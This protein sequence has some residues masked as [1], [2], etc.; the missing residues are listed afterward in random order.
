MSIQDLYYSPQPLVIAGP[1]AV[2]WTN[3]DTHTH[4]TTGDNGEWDSGRLDP[5]QSF[6]NTIL[7][8]RTYYFHCTIHTC[9]MGSLTVNP[10]SCTQ[11]TYTVTPTYTGTPPTSTPSVTPTVTNTPCTIPFTD[12]LPTDD[13][14]EGVHWLYCRGAVSGYGSVFLPY[15]N[16]TR[17]QITKIVVL[18]YSFT[19]YVPPTPTF[20]DV[21]TDHPF[22]QYIETAYHQDI[23]SGYTCGMGCL[24]FRPG[25]NVTRAQFCK[26]ITLAGCGGLNAAGGPHF[27]DVPPTDPFY[28]FIETAYNRGIISGYICGPNC[29]EF[30]PS[31][32]ATRGQICKI[33]YN[34]IMQP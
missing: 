8:P 15:N 4:T 27:R 25:N 33:V 28:S 17:G 3:N 22:Y 9:M 6:I 29:L 16:T 34:A 30:R 10:S 18:A 24:E 26:I 20:R 21:P 12:V 7:Y 13:F 32:S 5:G 11:P 1:V 14:Y 23:I 2:R 19:L 31:A